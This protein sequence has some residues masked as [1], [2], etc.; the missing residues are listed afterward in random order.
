MHQMPD[1]DGSDS[2]KEQSLPEEHC[3][4]AY[5][6]EPDTTSLTS[7]NMTALSSSVNLHDAESVCIV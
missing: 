3:L 7:G 4:S 2:G 5:P 1:E 6:H